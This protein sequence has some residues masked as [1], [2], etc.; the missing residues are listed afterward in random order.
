MAPDSAPLAQ[1][2]LATVP[3]QPKPR[4]WADTMR[5]TDELKVF[6][7]QVNIQLGTDLD[8][9]LFKI[10]IWPAPDPFG[11]YWSPRLDDPLLNNAR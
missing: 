8:T 3:F 2:N 7:P 11:W 9:V 1:L 6:D 4:V 5:K 10:A